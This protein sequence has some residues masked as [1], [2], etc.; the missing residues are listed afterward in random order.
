VDHDRVEERNLLRQ[1]F[2]E[3]ELGRFKAEALAE[4]L[5]RNF[6]VEVGYSV[7]PWEPSTLDSIPHRWLVIGCV[8]NPAAR[9]AIVASLGH[10]RC[11]WLDA[12]NGQT[13]G[14]VLL[15]DVGEAAGLKACFHPVTR[16]CSHLPLPT[17]QQPALLAV[18]PEP[19]PPQGCAQAVALNGQSPTINQVMAGLVLDF[20]HRLLTGTLTWM[21]MYLDLSAGTLR[22]V[23]AEPRQVAR[24]TGLQESELVSKDKGEPMKLCPKCGGYHA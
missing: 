11:W 7:Y 24:L 8:D 9:A 19:E 14:Q 5:A 6:G 12:G 13:S 23:E 21:G 1:S 15:G 18:S 20:V 4:R 3:R 16:V 17:L 22:P 2:Y 10:G